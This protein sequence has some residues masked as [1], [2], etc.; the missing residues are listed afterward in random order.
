MKRFHIALS[1]RDLDLPIRDYSA[2][3]GAAPCVLVPG[4]Y[5]LWRT[6]SLNVSIRKTSEEPGTVRHLGWEDPEASAFSEARDVNGLLW[7]RFTEAVGGDPAD[8]AG[9]AKAGLRTFAKL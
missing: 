5:A 1:V 3:L 4:E 6:Q 9:G 2:R 7:E 8:L